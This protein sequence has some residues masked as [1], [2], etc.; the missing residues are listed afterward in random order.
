[1]IFDA[2]ANMRS[3][4][5]GT[6]NPEQWLVDWVRG[7]QT[8]AAGESI[9]PATAL[10]CAA[11]YAAN[12]ILSETVASLPLEVFKRL[13]GGGKEPA[14]DHPVYRLLHDEPNDEVSSFNWRET[15]QL[16]VGTWGNAYSEIQR[17]VAGDPV[18]IWGISPKPEVMKPFRDMDKVVKYRYR[19]E[20]GG[21]E[22]ILQKRDVLHI[23]G[24][25]FDGLVGYS[26]ISLMKEAIGSAKAS[27][28]YAAELFANNAAYAGVLQSPEK[29]SD[30][31]YNRLTD[32]QKE[33]S[34]H[35]RRHQHLILEEGTQ[36]ASTQMNPSD[37][38]MIE[39][40]RFSIEEIARMYRITLHLLQEFTEGAAS[41]ASIVELGREF[42]VYT[43]L[44]ILR[45]FCA[46]INRKLLD[47]DHF[48][49][50]NVDA[51]L[52]GDPAARAEV[53]NKRFMCGGTT[54]NEMCAKENQ[55]P[56]GPMGDVR[57]V[58]KNLI[59]LEQAVKGQEKKPPPAMP[60]PAGSD[61]NGDGRAEEREEDREQPKEFQ[62][63][64]AGIRAEYEE[65]GR[66]NQ[67]RAAQAARQVIGDVMGR[68]I[69]KE[70]NAARRAA[71]RPKQFQVWRDDFYARHE[72]T[73]AEAL[74]H[75]IAVLVATSGELGDAAAIAGDWARRHC[76]ANKAALL[77]AA[78]CKPAELP[79][80]V[81]AA[82]S[83]FDIL[84]SAFCI[85]EYTH[86]T[87]TP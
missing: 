60:P 13:P 30:K 4:L 24:M 39:A 7:G 2:I 49:E 52:E 56:I 33:R 77:A 64:L 15:A 31:A 83:Q 9:S 32:A 42:I 27:E 63:A 65:L 40:R 3:R 58:P 59:P 44:S 45:R 47:A 53:F 1:M 23:P 17:T 11:V 85:E 29:L 10:T 41:Y 12:K 80:R 81:E 26:P 51:F 75:P 16:H 69:Y 21:P 38:Q 76:D 71:N 78:E 36:F 70:R 34:S 46:E 74:R 84:H 87:A 20:Q 50:F 35:G 43:M 25:G 19:P 14:Y 86:A 55:P 66:R 62:S 5:S 37:V 18:A 28:R 54:I 57:F 8:T 72:A 79:A 6:A 68:M 22:E 82:V 67:A 48:A 61:G 73:I